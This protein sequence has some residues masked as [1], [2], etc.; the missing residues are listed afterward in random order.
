MIVLLFPSLIIDE[1][2]WFQA[3]D[4]AQMLTPTLNNNNNN[5]NNNNK[6]N[7]T[8]SIAFT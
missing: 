6:K 7:M 8:I 3:C 4:C 2:H 5:N 1:I